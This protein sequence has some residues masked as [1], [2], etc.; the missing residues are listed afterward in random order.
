MNREQGV[1]ARPARPRNLQ[2]S[3]RVHHRTEKGV[4]RT[5]FSVAEKVGFEPTNR[6]T[7]YTISNRA[8][9]TKLGD[10][11]KYS[12]RRLAEAFLIS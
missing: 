7:G 9:S 4:L 1:Q 10:F 11:S 6:F 2:G 12:V 3:H 8:P 5:P